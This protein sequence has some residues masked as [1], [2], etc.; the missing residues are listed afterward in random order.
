[1]VDLLQILGPLAGWPVY[2][3]NFIFGL[4]LGSFLNSWIWRRREN[5][6]IV[7][8]YSVCV[9]CRRDLKWW[10]NIPLFSFL[11]LKGKCSTCKKNIPWHYFAVEFFTGLIFLGM[12]YYHLNT[13]CFSEW[14]VMRDVLFVTVLI[15]VFVYDFRYQLIPVEVV[16]I[17]FL[18]GGAIN[19]LA[20]GYTIENLIIGM[21]IGGGFFLLQYVVSKGRWIGGGDVRL[22]LMMGIWLGYPK[23]LLALFIAYISGA[24]VGTFLLLTKKADR[25]TA[26]PFGTFL[27]IGTFIAIFQGDYIINWFFGLLK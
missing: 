23:I 18:F 26:I 25:Q 19:L 21:L 4:I 8:D 9:H 24:I 27:A 2:I 11:F 10:E 7:G 17:G 14:L 6:R 1:M 3:F 12:T 15:I 16:W 20:L 5:I 22:G 13:P